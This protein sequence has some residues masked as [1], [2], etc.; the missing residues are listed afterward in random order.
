VPELLSNEE[1]ETEET[2]H[3]LSRRNAPIASTQRADTDDEKSE[4]QRIQSGP[5]QIERARNP[6]VWWCSSNK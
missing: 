4:R 2:C 1:T 3:D 6:N 5:D